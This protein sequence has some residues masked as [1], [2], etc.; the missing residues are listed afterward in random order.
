MLCIHWEIYVCDVYIS[1]G[2][3]LDHLPIKV[4]TTF[5]RP[6]LTISADWKRGRIL[7]GARS[8][9]ST[10]DM[11]ILHPAPRPWMVRPAMI[12]DILGVKALT[13]DPPTKRNSPKS[14]IG[15]LVIQLRHD[16]VCIVCWYVDV[17]PSKDIR[18]LVVGRNWYE[19]VKLVYLDTQIRTLPARPWHVT[20]ANKYAVAIHAC[21]SGDPR[22]VAIIVSA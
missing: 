14:K 11:A 2:K 3:G 1:K 6:K 21:W 4:P 22:S 5:A 12:P 8:T 19:Q 10:N 16:G 17:V 15:F 7:T 20:N 13:N 18:K 9:T